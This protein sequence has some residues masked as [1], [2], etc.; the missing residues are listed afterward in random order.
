MIGLWVGGT[1][2]HAAIPTIRPCK[3]LS[4]PSCTCTPSP[5]STHLEPGG[6]AL[7]LVLLPHNLVVQRDALRLAPP[8]AVAERAARKAAVGVAGEACL[9]RCCTRSR[10][11]DS[12]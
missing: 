7:I 12:C 6:V 8:H 3:S 4:L 9:G 10:S 1:A 11:S 5:H 2:R